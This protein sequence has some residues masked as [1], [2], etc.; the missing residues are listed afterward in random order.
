MSYSENRQRV[1]EIYGINPNDCN[2]NCHHIISKSDIKKNLV[3]PDFDLDCKSNLYP[4]ERIKHHELHRKIEKLEQVKESKENIQTPKRE[5]IKGR[6]L[7]EKVL[8]YNLRVDLE[9]LQ[10]SY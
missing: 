4:I 2:Y 6:L 10:Q 5:K 9:E 8:A 1:F 3:I 7:R